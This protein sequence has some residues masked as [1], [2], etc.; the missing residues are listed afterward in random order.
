MMSI[1]A[2]RL[3]DEQLTELIVV[4]GSA[5]DIARNRAIRELLTRRATATT[6]AA[7]LNE[8]RDLSR[9]VDEA[10]GPAMYQAALYALAAATRSWL[11]E[12]AATVEGA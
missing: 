2:P 7:R 11:R 1:P 3:S 9:H 5:N 4:F 8:L 12:I 6:Q 10:D